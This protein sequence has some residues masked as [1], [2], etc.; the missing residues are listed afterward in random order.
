MKTTKAERDEWRA[1]QTW[2]QDNDHEDAYFCPD[3]VTAEFFLALLD[4]A[5]RAEELEK[6]LKAN[7]LVWAVKHNG[8][9]FYGYEQ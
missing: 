8:E 1:A 6:A 9:T 4:D 3:E 2:L 5:D 7:T